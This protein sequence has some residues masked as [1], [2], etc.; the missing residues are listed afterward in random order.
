MHVADCVLLGTSAPRGEFS[1]RNVAHVVE[2][3]DES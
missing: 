1:K 2:S 3:S